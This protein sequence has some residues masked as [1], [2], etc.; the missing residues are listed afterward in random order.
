MVPGDTPDAFDLSREAAWEVAAVDR[1]VKKYQEA[2]RDARRADRQHELPPARRALV[3]TVGPVSARIHGMQ[4]TAIE[5][6]GSAG[7]PPGWHGPFLAFP[8]DVLALVAV[9]SAVR[10]PAMTS[11]RVG[12]PVT[13]FSRWIAA[14]LRD[15]ADHDRF[16]EAQRA[17]AKADKEN[18]GELLRR[19][20]AAHPDADRRAWSRFA[21]KVE[22]ARSQAWG[23]DIRTDVGAALAK[24]LVEGAPD[25]F[26]LGRVGDLPEHRNPMCILLTEKAVEKMAD[27]DVRVEVARP[28]MLPMICPPNPWR[29]APAPERAAA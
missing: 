21:A 2:A 26:E 27:V 7:R 15:Q 3:E 28:L 20:L 1:A 11:G 25:W 23:D 4:D 16:V 29:Y 18:G 8:A 19:F 13:G 17:E 14:T 9:T 12:Q 6:R 22:G 10:S 24:A 5:A